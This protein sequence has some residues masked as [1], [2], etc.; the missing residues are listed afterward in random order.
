M[1]SEKYIGI[2]VWF[3]EKLGFGFISRLNEQDLFVHWSDISSKGFKT[4]KKGQEVAFSI[5]VN[6]KNKP[7]AIEVVVVKDSEG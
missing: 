6:N 5:G 4:L 7:K 3:N 1:Q 2:V